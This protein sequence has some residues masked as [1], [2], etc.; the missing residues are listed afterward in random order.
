MTNAVAVEKGETPHQAMSSITNILTFFALTFAW[1]WSL[2]WLAALTKSGSPS[3]SGVL[4]LASAFGPGL[5]A[6]L[7]TLMFEGVPGLRRWM[8]T[9]LTWR[10]GWRWYALAMLVP[11]LIMGTALAV[12]WSIGGTIPPLPSARLVMVA[13]AQF[14]LVLILGGPLGEEFGWRGYA[15][16]K[17]SERVGWRWAGVI[18]GAAWTLWHVPLLLMADT[19]QADLP[20]IMF[21]VSTIG[22]SVVMSRLSVNARFSVL[23]AILLHSVINWCSMVLPIMPKGGDAQAYSLVATI[24]I[25]VA[26]IALVKPGPVSS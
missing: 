7:T 2:W 3:L 23:P 19:A 26:L 22:L 4:F 21:V 17:L 5:A 16:P 24:T 18:V 25:L 13:L 14:P 6:I 9:C 15:L 1:T 12:Q 10:I 11:P 20:M 8:K